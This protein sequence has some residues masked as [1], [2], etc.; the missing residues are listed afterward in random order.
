MTITQ[1]PTQMTGTQTGGEVP[2]VE[3]RTFEELKFL[4]RPCTTNGDH[5]SKAERVTLAKQYADYLVPADKPGL[6]EAI[7]E[8]FSHTRE[9]RDIIIARIDSKS[10]PAKPLPPG[11]TLEDMVVGKWPGDETDEQIRLALEE[12]S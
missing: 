9:E 4:F 8:G 10:R 7:A 12:L 6:R 1:L 5:L 11:K 2:T 3:P